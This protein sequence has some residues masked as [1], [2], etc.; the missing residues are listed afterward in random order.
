MM[1]TSASLDSLTLSELDPHLAVAKRNHQEIELT[2]P[3]QVSPSE[4]NDPN[5]NPD[6]PTSQFAFPVASEEY[7]PAS[8]FGTAILNIHDRSDAPDQDNKDSKL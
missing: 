1:S 7:D 2:S 6:P 3:I 8:N 4:E 5:R